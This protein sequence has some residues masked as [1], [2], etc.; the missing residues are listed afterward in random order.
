MDVSRQYFL[1]SEAWE[2]W[3]ESTPTT[4]QTIAF[5][6]VIVQRRSHLIPD[7]NELANFSPSLIDITGSLI[8]ALAYVDASCFDYALFP[9][10]GE[11]YKDSQ[12]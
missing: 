12:P 6:Y 2:R 4:R 5:Y 10:R 7:P 11:G 8:S 1:H 3:R 9:G